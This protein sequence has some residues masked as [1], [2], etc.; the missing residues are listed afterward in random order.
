MGSHNKEPI[1]FSYSYRDLLVALVIV[2]M[3]I[4]VMVLIGAKQLSKIDV[5]PQGLVIISDHWSDASD[6]DV[7]L[8]VKSP[9][10]PVPTGY[11]H[12]S[13]V[14]CNL[15]RDDLGRYID[16][17]STNTEMTVCKR[18]VSGEWITGIM[19]YDN[20]DHQVPV[21]VDVTVQEIKHGKS[22]IILNKRFYL[23]HKGQYLTTWRWTFDDKGNILPGSVNNIPMNLYNAEHSDSISNPNYTPNSGDYR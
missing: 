17:F 18:P 9:D 7:D 22:M 14:D 21:W 3:A 12:M 6:S 1:G 19:L 5:Y 16:P 2:Y 4:A 23:D 15:L 10:D 20:Y 8:W 13:G 11:S